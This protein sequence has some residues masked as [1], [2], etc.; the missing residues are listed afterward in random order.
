M[1]FKIIKNYDELC[2]LEEEWD[3]L[4][5]NID[6]PQV[7]YKFGWIKAYLDKI[8]FKLKNSLKIIL[9]YV[10]KELIAIFP[11]VLDGKT[12]RF[13]T[14]KTVDYN[15]IYIRKDTNKY[16]LIEKTLE[17][18]YKDVDFDGIE[19]SNISGDS[20]LYILADILRNKENQKVVLEDSVMT[21]ILT[22]SEDSSKKIRKKQL[23]DIDRR[24]RKLEKENDLNME[25]GCDIDGKL[26]DFICENHKKKWEHSVFNIDEYI[27]FYK[28]IISSMKSHIEASKLMINDEIVAAH[29]GF[30]DE[31]KVYYYIPT[32]KEE[33]SRNAVG[34]IL[35]KEIIDTY[36]DKIEFD[37][38][39]GNEL[40]KFN[41]TDNVKMNYNLYSYKGN[42][43]NLINY[44]KIYLKKSKLLRRIL[45][46]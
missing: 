20:E 21:P 22:N 44:Q 41:W 42:I 24:R 6:N 17:Y 36:N 30:K 13:V 2:L 26:W 35:L 23:K 45:K 8:D 39:R 14:N 32:Y 15:N 4:I 34:Y 18:I 11:F 5:N 27:D 7:F 38:L 31:R 46:K 25:I 33:F 29:F 3:E 40:Y 37:F 9:V 43:K 10:K 16:N 19:L 12:L 28:E 1:E